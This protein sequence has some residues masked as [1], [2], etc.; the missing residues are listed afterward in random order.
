VARVGGHWCTGGGH[1]RCLL[2]AL[3]NW[4]FEP[5][6]PTNDRDGHWRLGPSGFGACLFAID[7]LRSLPARVVG[8]L[9]EIVAYRPR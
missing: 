4:G 7:M 2:L 3:V 6:I 5:I 9:I 1:E 8:T